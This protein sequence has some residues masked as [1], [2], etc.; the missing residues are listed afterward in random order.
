MFQYEWS[1]QHTYGNP[2]IL[3]V[4]STSV[5]EARKEILTIFS[6]LESVGRAIQD[7]TEYWDKKQK[8]MLEPL[9][10]AKEDDINVYNIMSIEYK[11]MWEQR[12]EERL[13][14]LEELGLNINLGCYAMNIEDYRL[15]TPLI[16]ENKKI[17]NVKELINS[18]PDIKK[19][20]SASIF[21]G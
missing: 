15:F 14:L 17:K 3:S 19:F 10:K 16:H 1:A 8:E 18:D 6:K 11:K 9:K 4:I 13:I 7:V 21:S 5:E 20:K 2:L 12:C